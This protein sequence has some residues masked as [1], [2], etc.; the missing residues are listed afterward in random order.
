MNPFTPKNVDSVVAALLE[1]VKKLQDVAAS[2]T[3][4]AIK[5]SEVINKASLAKSS[6]EAEAARALSISE[7]LQNLL[8]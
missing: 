8:A 4:E 5:Q 6:A 7:K 1:T 2:Q 3:N